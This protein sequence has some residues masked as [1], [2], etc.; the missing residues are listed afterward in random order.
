MARMRRSALTISTVGLLCLFTVLSGAA[1]AV[2]AAGGVK[3]DPQPELKPFVIGAS[4]YAGGS[5]AIEPNG[6]LVVARGSTSGNGK[7]VVC[8]LARGASKCSSTVTLSPLGSDDLFG[9]PEVFIPSANHVTVLAETCCDTNPAGSDLLFSST[10]GGRTFAAPKRVGTLGVN[11]AALIKG[12]IVFTQSDDNNGAEVE[13]IP[14]NASGPPGSTAVANSKEAFDVAMGSYKGGALIASDFLGADYTTYVEYAPAGKN[15][16]A[17]GSYLPVG[18]FSHE[19]LIAMSGDALLTIKTTGSQALELRLF[20]G[21]TFGAAHAVPHSTGGAAEWFTVDQDPRGI[22]HVFSERALYPSTPYLLYEESTSTGASWSGPVVL[23]NAIS[24]NTF[25]V[26]LDSAGSGLVLGT[27]ADAAAWGYPVL[28]T[29]GASFSLKSATI[30]RG[31]STIGSGSG[32]PAAH[33]RV[34]ELQV[35][36]SGLWYTVATTR[37][38]S[39][40]KFSFT[41]KGT[42]AGTFS[43]RA[44]VLDLAGYIMYGYS[45]ARSLRVTS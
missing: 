28:A 17:S 39:T 30:K 31:S 41:I 29:Q 11:A 14:V 9:V 10:D 4:N 24:S 16:N 36:R 13:S 40:G 20:N 33:G 2:T 22:V 25:G 43:Y 32:S 19:Q 21:K 38:S 34:V 15:F 45:P 42:S 3:G 8:V 5:V 6:A 35:E 7:V 37:E 26:A 12:D 27:A 23:G 44:V 18:S 1:S